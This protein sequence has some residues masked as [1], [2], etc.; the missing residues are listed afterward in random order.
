MSPSI[1]SARLSLRNRPTDRL[2]DCPGVYRFF[3]DDNQ[4]LYVGKSIDVRTRVLSHY[5][6]ARK[7]GR[8][9]R[10]MHAVMRVDSEP[11]AGEFGA[12]LRENAAIKREI[13]LYNRRQRRRRNLWTLGLVGGEDGFQGAQPQQLIVRGALASDSYGLYHSAAHG[14]NALRQLARDHGLCLRVLGL[15]RGRGPCFAYQLRRC[16]GACA[17]AETAPE[18]NARL[19]QAL[20]DQRILAWPF[21]TA[22]LL[23]E[24]AA[25]LRP[26]QPRQ[27]WHAVDQWRYIGSYARRERAARAVAVPPDTGDDA[28]F[29][30]DAY[31]IL[32]RALRSAR[33][34]L[35]GAVSLETLENPLRHAGTA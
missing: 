6:A 15:E 26:G 24:T 3:G 16:A 20:Q 12:L 21:P 10:M 4:L 1:E 11:C 8:Q 5:A 18:H 30:R 25:E 35:H 9:Q 27:D 13:P 17:G 19:S 7:P 31:L 14:E 2:P 33:V 28:V 32:L 29:D 23:R 22:V 34:R